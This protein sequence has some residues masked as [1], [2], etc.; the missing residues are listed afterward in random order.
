VRPGGKGLL[1]QL[2]GV[3]TVEQAAALRGAEL[4]VPRDMLPAL[5]DG[6]YY[7]VDLEGLA[8]T[9]LD[10]EPLGIA[11]NVREYPAADVLRVRTSAGVW[12]VPMREPYLVSVDVPGGS[13][14]VDHLD[15]LELEH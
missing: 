9:T 13:I 11:E 3:A 10:G 14:V 5:E 4:C 2:A 6:E 15:D 1:V 7:F 12:E 8:V